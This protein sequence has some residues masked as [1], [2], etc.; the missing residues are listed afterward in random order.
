MPGLKIKGLC[1]SLFVVLVNAKRTLS[2]WTHG[3]CIAIV[4]IVVVG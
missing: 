2:W 4:V 3:F 1:S